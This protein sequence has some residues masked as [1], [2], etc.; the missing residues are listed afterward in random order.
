MEPSD[1]PI[2][3]VT[4]PS[5]P[6]LLSGVHGHY[7][8]GRAPTIVW[9]NQ[10][11]TILPFLDDGSGGNFLENDVESVTELAKSPLTTFDS[12]LPCVRFFT[13]DDIRATTFVKDLREVLA[14]GTVVVLPKFQPDVA[15][16]FSMD[17][18]YH[19][20]GLAPGLELSVH[21]R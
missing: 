5:P 4:E 8:D 21:G 11:R 18:I 13:R 19:H 12:Q 10:V 17:D 6:D 1:P 2:N 14:N 20:L 16:A 7:I 3:S 15:M 9:G